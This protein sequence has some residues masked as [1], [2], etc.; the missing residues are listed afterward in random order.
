MV[1]RGGDGE[2]L[3]K[4]KETRRLDH[5]TRVIIVNALPNACWITLYSRR[6]TKSDIALHILFKISNLILHKVM[7]KIHIQLIFRSLDANQKEI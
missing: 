5:Y 3:E 4:C 7:N 2:V 1:C 6:I